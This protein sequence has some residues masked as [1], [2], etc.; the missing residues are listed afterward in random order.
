VAA[1][2]GQLDFRFVAEFEAVSGLKHCYVEPR[3]SDWSALAQE[4]TIGQHTHAD[5]LPGH[6]RVLCDGHVHVRAILQVGGFFQNRPFL[7]GLDGLCGVQSPLLRSEWNRSMD[8]IVNQTVKS[9]PGRTAF[10]RTLGPCVEAKH[11][12]R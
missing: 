11:R 12:I 4:A 6:G 9:K 3:I 2:A 7:N 8:G 1:S 10:T 5:P